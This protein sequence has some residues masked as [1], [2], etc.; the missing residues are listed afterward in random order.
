MT[1]YQRQYI[2]IYSPKSN[3]QRPFCG[4]PSVQPPKTNIEL[5]TTH[6]EWPSNAGGLKRQRIWTHF[7]TS[8]YQCHNITQTSAFLPT[9][10]SVKKQDTQLLRITSS[11]VDRFYFDSWDI[12]FVI[13][14]NLLM[15]F[16]LIVFLPITGSLTDCRSFW[17][18]SVC[19]LNLTD[20]GYDAEWTTLFL[21]AS[22]KQSINYL[23]C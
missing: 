17:Y 5:P 7:S 21:Y 10:L 6:A 2:N 1:G 15:S 11:N 23:T 12:L 20:I 22:H 3:C 18:T 4:A 16:F 14:Q 8:V 9:F 13:I 19:L